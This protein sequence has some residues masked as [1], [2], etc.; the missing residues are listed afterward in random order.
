[1]PF[2]YGIFEG[3]A[4]TQ[5]EP[6]PVLYC[7]V[8]GQIAVHELVVAL[9]YGVAPEQVVPHTVPFNTGADAGHVDTHVFPCVYGAVLGQF[10][11]HVLPSA[12][13]YGYSKL[14]QA[15]TQLFPLEY[16]A[17]DGQL[18]TQ[19]EP[20]NFDEPVG[21]VLTHMFP[22][23]YGALPGQEATHVILLTYIDFGHSA[24]QTPSSKYGAVPG[25]ADTHVFP[26][27]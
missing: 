20:S 12:L 18:L 25:H 14:E 26:L 9:K 24:A 27:K 11:K 8:L 3:Q 15:F 22:Y 4:T 17:V 16:G 21:H 19:L 6:N 5:F 1:M 23:W 10:A 13:K 2:R 7:A